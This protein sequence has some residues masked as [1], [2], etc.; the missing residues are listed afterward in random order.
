VSSDAT[1]TDDEYVGFDIVDGTSHC[2]THVPIDDREWA[3]QPMLR[4][5]IAPLLACELVAVSARTDQRTVP[6]CFIEL[7]CMHNMQ[8]SALFSRQSRRP[9]KCFSTWVQNITAHATVP[10][11]NR[12]RVT[13]SSRAVVHTGQEGRGALWRCRN[14]VGACE[15]YPH[16]VWV[17]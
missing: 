15:T 5:Q 13:C 12:L 1:F 4:L 10:Y 17:S 7:N 6:R 14:P 16:H 2:C 3:L 11:G 8:L 9:I